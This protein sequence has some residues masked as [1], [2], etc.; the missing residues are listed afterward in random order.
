L[1]KGLFF[2]GETEPY[3]VEYKDRGDWASGGAAILPGSDPGETQW[4]RAIRQ[5]SPLGQNLGRAAL[6]E[7]VDYENGE[8]PP[9]LKVIEESR[10]HN[11]NP[12]TGD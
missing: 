6:P 12:V 8:E 2:M 4:L 11:Q 9:D 10:T 5:L 1:A 3:E 7:G